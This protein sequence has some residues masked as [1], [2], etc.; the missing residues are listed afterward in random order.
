MPASSPPQKPA[1]EPTK[2]TE[3]ASEATT[4][5]TQAE[6]P[7]A[8]SSVNSA[9]PRPPLEDDETYISTDYKGR[10]IS[11]HIGSQL[12]RHRA[13]GKKGPLMVGLQ[14]P[15]GCGEISVYPLSLH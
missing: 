8:K 10:I 3:K 6:E 1:A 5:L 11:H 15:Q 12:E 2:S 7:A 14:G 4:P 13:E 9:G